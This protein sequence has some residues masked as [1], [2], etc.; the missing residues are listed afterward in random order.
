MIKNQLF[1]ILMTLV[2]FLMFTV[3][4]FASE[5]EHFFFRYLDQKI[6]LCKSKSYRINSE[7]EC[8][9]RTAQKGLLM[10]QYLERNRESLVREMV[11]ENIEPKP[12]K[13]DYF[14]NERYS[15]NWDVN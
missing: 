13:I 10:A 11:A 3:P 7:S 1:G 8:I 4:L 9:R 14:L 15:E 2:I 12:Y 6:Y 5:N